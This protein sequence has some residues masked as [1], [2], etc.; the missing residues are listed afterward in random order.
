LEK[1]KIEEPNMKK[2]P[3]LCIFCLGMVLVFG[4]AGGLGST[5]VKIT[6]TPGWY[7]ASPRMAVDS[8][9][10]IH[11]VWAQYYGNA[12]TT[13]MTGDAMYAVYDIFSKQWTTPLNLTA[14]SQVHSEEYRPVGIDIDG[15]N[16]IYVIYVERSNKKVKMRICSGGNWGAPFELSTSAGTFDTARVAVRPNGD[17]YT[18]WWNMGEFR[19]YSRA[20]IGGTW[21]NVKLVS[22]GS[23]K[24]PDIAVGTD[25]AYMTW[26]ARNQAGIYLIYYAQRGTAYNAAWSSP[27]LLSANAQKQQ[28]PTVEVDSNDIAHIV[29]AQF[30]ADGG[31]RRMDY[32]YWQ[33]GGFSSPQPLSGTTLSHYPSMCETGNNIYAT[34]Q[35]GAWLNGS[36][37]H[38][39][40]KIMGAWR[41]EGS[42]AGSQGSTYPDVATSPYQ[43]KVYYVWDA[44]NE[45][46]FDSRT[47]FTIGLLPIYHGHDFDGDGMS[48]LG[49]W[50]QSDGNFYLKDISVTNWGSQGDAPACGDYNGDGVTDIA[51]W[52]PTNGYWFIKDVGEFEWGSL[53]DVPVPGDY[54]GDGVTELAVWK[55]SGGL[56][57]IQHVGVVQ[58]GSSGDIPVPGDYNGDGTTDLAVW[59]PSTGMWYIQNVGAFQWGMAGDIPVPGDYNGDLATDVAVWRPAL[60]MWFLRNIGSFQWGIQGDIPVPGKY[61]VGSTTDIAVWRPSQGIW[62]I[63]NIGSYSWGANGDIPLVR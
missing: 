26:T 10:N 25:V 58:W 1:R 27:Q 21:E 56:W 18:C 13:T 53:G 55:P 33:G 43:D 36:S 28:T 11:L 50:R 39:N 40:E 48:D 12:E 42:I 46:W 38:F 7:D 17:I 2:T 19:C 44:D 8:V 31:I 34:W 54:D 20:R 24:F 59:R 30:I 60:G 29:F 23:S 6:N 62:Y 9:G 22:T 4:L 57:V 52:R 49:V 35:L 47:L 5:P 15:S 41:G 16:N 63:R 51:V 37:V 45:L 32:S 61:D 3:E 14:N